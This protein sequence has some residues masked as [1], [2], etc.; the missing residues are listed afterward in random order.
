VGLFIDEAYYLYKPDNERDY[1][2]IEILLQVMENQRDDVVILA[3]YKNL[4]INSM[5][6]TLVYLHVLL[7]ISIS[8]IIQLKNYTNCQNNVRRPTISINS[9]S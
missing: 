7:I 4:W 1:G 9:T 5:N 8:Q 6:Q 2:S 3:G